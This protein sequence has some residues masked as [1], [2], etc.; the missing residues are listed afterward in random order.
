MACPASANL[1]KAI[2][3]WQ[4]PVDSPRFVAKGQGTD[5]HS[6]FEKAWAL[7][8]ADLRHFAKVVQYVADLR[9]TRRFSTLIEESVTATWLKTGPQ[10]TADLVLHTQDELHII[11]T[12]WGRI[13]VDVHDNAQLLYYAVCHAPLAPR[14]KGV[15]LHIL[16]PRADNMEKVFVPTPEIKKFMDEAIA[17]EQRI[18]AGD[19]TFGPSDHCKFCPA[20][21]HS[22]TEKGTPLCPATLQILY[23]K[24]V[25]EA[26]ILSL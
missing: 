19:V 15:T 12:K 23:P 8:A 14:A 26:E 3:G 7:S 25:D 17:A 2:L 11:D 21:P 5:V 24:V 1:D 6:I 22:R 18:L 9:S 13:E 10:T 4:E 20:Y 16:Q